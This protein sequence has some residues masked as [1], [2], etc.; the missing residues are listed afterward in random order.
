[1][2]APSSSLRLTLVLLLALAGLP[3]WCHGYTYLQVGIDSNFL[4]DD[5]RVAFAQADGSL[6]VLALDSGKVLSRNRVRDFSGTLRRLPQGALLVNER[7]IAL[8]DSANFSTFWELP[9]QREPTVAGDALIVWDGNGLIQCRDL[10]DGKVRWTCEL[11]G[12][13]EI[14]AEAGQVLIHRPATYEEGWLPTT[15]LLNVADGKERFRNSPTDGSHRAATFFDG[16]NIYVVTG[17]FKDKRADYE[18]ERLAIWNSAGEETGSLPIPGELR[19]PFRDGELVE[20]D[21]KA[22]WKGHVYADARSIPAERRGKRNAT[23]Q[24][25]S[26]VGKTFE[27][28]HDLGDGVRFIERARYLGATNSAD[29]AF[30]MEIEVRTPTNHW[31]GVLPYLVRGG[32]VAAVA[33]AQGK[34]LIGTDMG[35]VECL[36]ADTGRS[37]WLYTFPTLRRTV[38]F[39]SRSLP[40]M[41]SEAA[42]IFRRDNGTPPTSGLQVLN[43][44]AS[45]PTLISDPNPVDPYARLPLYRAVAWSLAGLAFGLLILVHLLGWIRRWPWSVSGAMTGWVTFLLFCGYLFFGRVSPLTSITLEISILTGFAFGML[46]AVGCYWKRLWFEGALL[47]VIFATIAVFVFLMVI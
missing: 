25:S 37:L 16:T 6:T 20:L 30:V 14:S 8:L 24:Q 22:F 32:R 3:C 28:E 11:P 18:P 41:M 39:R 21:G 27:T 1:M 34:I 35:Q 33:K 5:T 36:E 38:S 4:L 10:G 31:T 45:R 47:L 2:H 46:D 15:V 43:A 9:Y 40:P 12:A 29:A 23:A 17:S 13:L 26:E 44:K 19:Q 7:T 42:D